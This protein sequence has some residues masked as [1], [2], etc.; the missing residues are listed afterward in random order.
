MGAFIE[1]SYRLSGRPHRGK[2][3]NNDHACSLFQAIIDRLP[4]G[5]IVLDP[6]PFVMLANK[7]AR[8]I[9]ESNAY[10]SL[11][12][13]TLSVAGG[14]EAERFAAACAACLRGSTA[15]GVA[16]P[17]ASREL[18]LLVTRL[19]A[20]HDHDGS[21]NELMVVLS[22]R[23]ARRSSAIETVLEQMYRLT[24]AEIRVVQR[25]VDGLDLRSIAI[26]IGLSE[27]TVR[28]HLRSAFL[29]TRT[30]SQADLI[31]LL[32]GGVASVDCQ[33]EETE[34]LQ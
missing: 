4:M 26:D 2:N 34:P 21:G 6:P 12:N 8:R 23:T 30:H 14:T 7:A 20:G 18:E 33:R 16:V 10:I 3:G 29:K 24:S 31:R 5:V 19:E 13:G 27:H 22:D 32:V 11:E 9:A 17:S 15:A 25:L 28:T 1:Q